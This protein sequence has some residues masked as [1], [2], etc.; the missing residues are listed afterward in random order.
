MLLF[1]PTFI[2]NFTLSL[3]PVLALIFRPYFSSLL[4]TPDSPP[5]SSTFILSSSAHHISFFRL[6]IFIHSP[7]TTIFV[8]ITSLHP[9]STLLDRT[10]TKREHQ[11]FRKGTR[12]VS[13]AVRR[14]RTTKD[15]YVRITDVHI[16]FPGVSLFSINDV[17]LHGLED[18]N[19]QV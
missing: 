19:D 18:E 3:F 4:S 16:H 10:M 15:P 13:I 8:A 12:V 6:S 2:S 9:P 7:K 17:Y 14:D 5:S 1:F 11:C